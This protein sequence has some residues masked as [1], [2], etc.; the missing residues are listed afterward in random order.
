M[1]KLILALCLTVLLGGCG[2]L[3]NNEE[4][5]ELIE[6][7]AEFLELYEGSDGHKDSTEF[8]LRFKSID[9]KESDDS[10]EQEIFNENGITPTPNKDTNYNRIVASGTIDHEVNESN[11]YSFY[12]T[13][14]KSSRETVEIIED[15]EGTIIHSTFEDGCIEYEEIEA[16]YDLPNEDEEI[17]FVD[18]S[19]ENDLFV[20]KDKNTYRFTLSANEV[21]SEEEI[22]ELFGEDMYDSIKGTTVKIEYEF[23][24]G[25]KELKI[26]TVLSNII[27]PETNYLGTL[28]MTTTL[29]YGSSLKN[30]TVI[31]ATGFR[32]ALKTSKDDFMI[33]HHVGVE[34]EFALLSD[35]EN[36]AK[37][38]F[39]KSAYV[40]SVDELYSNYTIQ[41]LDK[42]F[43]V[44]TTFVVK[45]ITFIIEESDYYYVKYSD[46]RS[47][48]KNDFAVI[49][50]IS[51][52][53]YTDTVTETGLPYDE[54][55]IT[56]VNESKNDK[57]LYYFD[58]IVDNPSLAILV[59]KNVSA[60]LQKLNVRI[61]NPAKLDSFM[62]NEIYYQ[63]VDL[64]RELRIEVYANSA[65]D[66]ELNYNTV[67]IEEDIHYL[68]DYSERSPLFFNEENYQ[69]VIT[70]PIKDGTPP[71]ILN[72]DYI[73]TNR[74]NT[75]TI[76]GR[77]QTGDL[78]QLS[79]EDQRIENFTE[80]IIS[81]KGDY[82]GLLLVPSIEYLE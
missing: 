24:A 79:F 39:D 59:V 45:E 70:I 13:T 16:M 5:I 23:F 77:D 18:I 1:K 80:I 17:S 81:I 15:Y 61:S 27:I 65:M 10:F 38:Y 71:F 41:L 42:D 75:F 25:N 50:N 30:Y 28:K 72:L 73:S 44:L 43:N 53:G 68:T 36:Y 76:V 47:I 62:L 69:T 32:F 48:Y 22:I 26:Y 3:K 67:L 66:F 63:I 11:N 57:S 21:F 60:D 37:Y 14:D 7:E 35:T 31:G 8:S 46:N 49:V 82:T 78:I 40:F 51:D 2:F 34:E 4:L 12:R 19:L 56:G 55:I 54:G 29:K 6:K 33:E 9:Y 58:P 64:S 74:N 20:I 52:L